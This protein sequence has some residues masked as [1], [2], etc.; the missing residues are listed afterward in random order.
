MKPRESECRSGEDVARLSRLPGLA[1]AVQRFDFSGEIQALR[2]QEAWRR[3][4]GRSSK[5]L[6]KH[7]DFRIVVVLMK[8]D[9]RMGEHR[10]QA[11]ISLQPLLGRLGIHISGVAVELPAGA[12]LALDCG[13][14]HE[15]EAVEESAFLLT[16]SWPKDYITWA[17]GDAPA[18]AGC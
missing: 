3:A 15:I 12:L 17:A 10:A 1:G 2:Q 9:T 13:L 7:Q 8:A 4:A 14:R 5:T 11:R 6:V 16:V 18:L